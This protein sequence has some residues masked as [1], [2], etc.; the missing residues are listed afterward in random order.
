MNTF[1][2]ELGARA[3]AAIKLLV[4][5]SGIAWLDGMIWKAREYQVAQAVMVGMMPHIQDCTDSRLIGEAHELAK[6][7][8]RKVEVEA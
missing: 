2:D 1:D 7:L 6:Q 8:I 4:P 3:H 5:D